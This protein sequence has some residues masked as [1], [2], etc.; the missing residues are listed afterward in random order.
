M[1]KKKEEEEK[2]GRT[3]KIIQFCVNH[4]G[5]QQVAPSPFGKYSLPTNYFDI[6]MKKERK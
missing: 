5:I 3:R 6:K 4:H 2:M 1:I